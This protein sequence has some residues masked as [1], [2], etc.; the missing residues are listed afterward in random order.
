MIEMFQKSKI[1][2]IN[3][4]RYNEIIVSKRFNPLL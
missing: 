4:N 1:K 3:A 2:S